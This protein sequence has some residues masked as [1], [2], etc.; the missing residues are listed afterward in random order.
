MSK[1]DVMVRE[2]DYSIGGVSLTKNKP[3][4]HEA[5]HVVVSDAGALTGFNQDMELVWAFPPGEWFGLV[6][7]D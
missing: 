1:Y 2:F 6:R 4:E 7:K 3:V 5:H